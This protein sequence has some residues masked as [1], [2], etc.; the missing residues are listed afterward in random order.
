MKFLTQQRK[1]SKKLSLIYRETDYSFD[2]EPHDGSGFTSIMVNDLQLEID[3]RG[4]I[5]YVWGL[6]PL[7]KYEEINE[8]PENYVSQSLTAIL[9]RPPVPG[10]AYQLNEKE[11]WPIYI[12]KKV[13]W[14]CIGNPNTK[15][16]KMIEF[17]PD[18]VAT[19]EDQEIIAI[20]LKP[21]NSL[22]LA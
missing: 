21:K 19:L 22:K 10:I 6:C 4:E 15:N 13:G 11:R 14:V 16:K 7:F 3:D 8:A 12:N 5:I 2:T 1:T 20:W 18:C 17:V 9:G